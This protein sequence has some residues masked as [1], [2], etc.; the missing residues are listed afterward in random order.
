MGS[1]QEVLHDWRS[2]PL[3][4]T[5]YQ[6]YNLVLLNTIGQGIK[7]FSDWWIGTYSSSTFANSNNVIFIIVYVSLIIGSTVLLF[8]AGILSPYVS[9]NN[10]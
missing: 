6:F 9:I 3:P 4:R 5:K 7:A 10:T 8:A 1:L 2:L